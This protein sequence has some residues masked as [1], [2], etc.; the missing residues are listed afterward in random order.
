MRAQVFGENLSNNRFITFASDFGAI[1]AGTYSR[2]RY[3]GA[4]LGIEL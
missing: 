2:P 3:F 1:M 4:A